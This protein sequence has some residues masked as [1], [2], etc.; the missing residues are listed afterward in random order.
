MFTTVAKYLLAYQ[1]RAGYR[2]KAK[3]W[4]WWSGDQSFRAT[5][6]KVERG[7]ETT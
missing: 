3:S 4:S 1:E 7:R 6:S 2:S 5:L